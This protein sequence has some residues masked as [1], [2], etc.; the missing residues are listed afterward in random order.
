MSW[1]S[2][3]TES[4]SFDSVLT[5]AY[6]NAVGVSGFLDVEVSVIRAGYSGETAFSKSIEIEIGKSQASDRSYERGVTIS[7]SDGD[8]GDYFAVRITQ[9]PVYGTPVFTTMG[10]QSKCP[11][12]IYMCAYLYSVLY[13]LLI[14]AL[15]KFIP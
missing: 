11:G 8:M 5:E 3:I 7:M 1:S 13:M 12:I 9:D 4:R 14:L 2:T 10:G 15:H 6:P